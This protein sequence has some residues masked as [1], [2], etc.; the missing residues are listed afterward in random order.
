MVATQ[1][2][3]VADLLHDDFLNRLTEERIRRGL[4]LDRQR[5]QGHVW[6]CRCSRQPPTVPSPTAFAA[7]LAQTPV[8]VPMLTNDF[9]PSG[10]SLSVVSVNPA[11]GTAAIPRSVI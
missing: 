6:S 8:T 10:F 2:K 7:T 11:N 4:A 3:G 5:N 9:D 1:A